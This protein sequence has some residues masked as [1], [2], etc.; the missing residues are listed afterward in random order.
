MWEVS[1]LEN[2]PELKEKYLPRRKWDKK[3]A[4]ENC[5]ESRVFGAFSFGSF[6]VPNNSI[7]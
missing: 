7:K 5:Q 3:K 2:Q 1:P 4:T 6:S